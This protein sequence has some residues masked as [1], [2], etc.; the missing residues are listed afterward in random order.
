M[1]AFISARC[2]KRKALSL[3]QQYPAYLRDHVLITF[4]PTVH[5]AKFG[6][7]QIQIRPV[8]RFNRNKFGYPFPNVCVSSR[9]LLIIPVTV[10]SEDRS[11]C[12]LVD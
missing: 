7:A 12:K 1:E 5:R 3:E 6:S 10:A 11:F 8:E 9:I 2:V 4:L